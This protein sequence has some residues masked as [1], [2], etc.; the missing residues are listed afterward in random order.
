MCDC[1]CTLYMIFFLSQKKI[2]QLIRIY[3]YVW[4]IQYTRNVACPPQIFLNILVELS[5]CRCSQNNLFNLN[6]ETI[7]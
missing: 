3:T 4:F 2:A 6:N 1:V 7:E 5:G